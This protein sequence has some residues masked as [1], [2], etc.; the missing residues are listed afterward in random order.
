[1]IKTLVLSGQLRREV[2]ADKVPL[3]QIETTLSLALNPDR[4]SAE[5]DYS[6]EVFSSEQD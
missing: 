1:V 2:L 6:I 4:I 3:E 5:N